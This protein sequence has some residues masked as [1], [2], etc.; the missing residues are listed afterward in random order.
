MGFALSSMLAADKGGQKLAHMGAKAAAR[1]KNN[2]RARR[3]EKQQRRRLPQFRQ[4]VRNL[5]LTPGR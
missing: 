2:G 1:V 4:A 5:K 3:L